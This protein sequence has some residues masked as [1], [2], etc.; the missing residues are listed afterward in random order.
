MVRVKHAFSMQVENGPSLN[1]P[2]NYD[3]Q[4]IDSGGVLVPKTGDKV[5]VNIQPLPWTRADFVVIESSQYHESGLTYTIGAAKDVPLNRAQFIIG[6]PLVRLLG[7][8]LGD[9]K[10][11]NNNTPS[12]VVIKVVVGRKASTS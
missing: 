1:I 11:T 12:D 2:G 3:V 4:V 9:L 6:N 7:P 10:I 5:T 8:A